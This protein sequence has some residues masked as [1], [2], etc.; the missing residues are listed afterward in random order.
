MNVKK[1][2]MI[3]LLV[4]QFDFFRGWLTYDRDQKE[5]IK[6]KYCCLNAVLVAVIKELPVAEGQMEKNGKLVLCDIG[7]T[8]LTQILKDWKEGA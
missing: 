5:L 7:I 4:R 8:I 2:D 3:A 1:Y 6:R